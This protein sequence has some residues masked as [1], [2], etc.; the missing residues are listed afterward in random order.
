[1]FWAFLSTMDIFS[2]LTA[3]EGVREVHWKLSHI[4]VLP[5]AVSGI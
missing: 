2:I 3:W 1:M 4:N 5:S